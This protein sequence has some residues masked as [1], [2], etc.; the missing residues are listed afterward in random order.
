MITFL[1][2]GTLPMNYF[3]TS[4]PGLRVAG[5]RITGFLLVFVG[6]K[7]IVYGTHDI[8]SS[9]AFWAPVPDTIRG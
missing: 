7:F 9:A 3:G 6:I 8:L 1:L 5:G 4:I 2:L